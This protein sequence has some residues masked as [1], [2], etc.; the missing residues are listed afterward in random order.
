MV[1]GGYAV[2]F[3]GYSRS[4]GDIDL[5]IRCSRKNAEKVWKA[6]KRFGAPLFDLT[7]KDLH[8]LGT[9]FQMGVIPSR[10]DLILKIDGVTYE[11]AWKAHISI[12]IDGMTIPVIGKD[13]LLINKKASN[14]P[15]DQND[16]LWIESEF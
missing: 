4:T 1:V 8:T 6:L 11:E 9:V 15:K 12:D 2:A 5:W 16:I 14:R 10:I 3:H 7:V 13:H